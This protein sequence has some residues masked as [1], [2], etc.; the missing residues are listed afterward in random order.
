MGAILI[1]LAVLVVGFIM[2]YFSK[3]INVTIN[4]NNSLPVVPEQTRETVEQNNELV[5][6]FPDEVTKW[7]QENNGMIK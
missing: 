2:G 6:M 1:L 4:K 3:G 5:N 7:F